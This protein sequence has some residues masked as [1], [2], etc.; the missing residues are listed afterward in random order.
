MIVMS[1]LLS[2]G[3][4][5]GRGRTRVRGRGAVRG[6]G[7]VQRGRGGRAA[8]AV[9]PDPLVE[10]NMTAPTIP[11]FTGQ[12]GLKVPVGGTKPTD[13]Y[14]LYLSDDLVE[15]FVTET[16]RYA[17]QTIVTIG[18]QKQFTRLK[19][20]RE[21]DSPEMKKFIGLVLLT[22]LVTKPS[23]ESYWS[24]LPILYTPIFSQIMPRNRF[25]AL[26]RFWHCN[27]NSH[28]PARN[29]PNRDRLFKI[30]PLVTHLQEK[31]Q[32]VYTPDKFVA[33]DESLLLWKGQ[34]VFKQYIPLKR[35]RFGIKLFNVCE[36]TGYT[37]KFHI[38][39]GKE[40]PG[41]QIEDQIPP[42]AAHLTATEKIV[43]FMMNSLLDQG[44]QLF[45]DNWY[46]GSRLYLYMMRRKTVCCGTMRENR[47]PMAVRQLVVSQQEPMKALR[48]GPLL[49]VKWQ[50]SKVVYM[51][52]TMHSE[53]MQQVTRR[54]GQK[55]SKPSCVVSYNSKMGG[56]D[57]ADQMLQPYD[58]TRKT[59]RW[60]KK[61]MVHLLQV[62]LLNSFLVFKK[63]QGSSKD[64]VTFQCD[65][66]SDLLFADSPAPAPQLPRT[67]DVARLTE[68]HFLSHVPQTGG[69]RTTTRKCKVCTKSGTRK[70]TAF[71]C[72]QCPSHPALCVIPC[73]EVYHTQ[74]KY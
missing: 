60:Y 5:L 72:K 44:Y 20:W 52:S 51:L 4:D 73:F 26:L 14:R 13:Y 49:F 7:G 67:E 36:D 16:N 28:E 27:D 25:Q 24:T 43:V 10:P 18:P 12:P 35:A 71:C 37:Y 29:S 3:E 41:F 2:S 40:D 59:T 23:I 8:A 15:H 65:V 48:S 33:V 70:E 45:M 63:D 30:R 9:L 62:S 32:L 58:A 6:R 1:V 68:R 39:T 74:K 34:L 66:I 61:V 55:V 47:A 46:T 50:S 31:F 19:K 22:G 17:S 64:F 53:A 38:Y 57:R 69:K 54:G 42:E 56:V 21:A 11:V